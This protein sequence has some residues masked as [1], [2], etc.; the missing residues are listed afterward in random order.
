MLHIQHIQ[1][2]FR[3]ASQIIVQIIIQDKVSKRKIVIDTYKDVE[4]IQSVSHVDDILNRYD[5]IECAIV[6]ASFDNAL[7]SHSFNL[8]QLTNSI[9]QIVEFLQR[10]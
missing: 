5:A 10:G 8:R 6:Q 9:C 1:Y 2:V 4:L 7:H 3:E